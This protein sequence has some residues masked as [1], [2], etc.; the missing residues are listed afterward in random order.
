MIYLNEARRCVALAYRE[1]VI[2]SGAKGPIIETVTVY[3]STAV[4]GVQEK[5]K[6]GLEPQFLF[7]EE[8]KWALGASG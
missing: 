4:T 2:S 5:E 6:V 3:L 7:R 8:P 1:I